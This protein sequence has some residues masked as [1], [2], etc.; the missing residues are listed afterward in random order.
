MCGRYVPPDEASLAR[1]WQVSRR[2]WPG[3]IKPVFN[4]APTMQV[5]IMLQAPDGAYELVGARWGLIPSWWSKAALPSLSFNARSEEALKKPMWRS[6]LHGQRCILP[7]LG[8][9]E[10]NEQE[11]TRNER[12]RKVNQPYF[13]HRQD[14]SVLAIAGLWSTWVGPDQSQILSCALLTR[15]AAPSISSIHHRMPVVLKP[16]HY[17]NWM[18]E[19]TL[20]SEVQAMIADS[21]LDFRGYAVSTKV[22]DVRN[23]GCEL[24]E[25][26]HTNDLFG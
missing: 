22:N 2:N 26:L 4:I 11:N 16:E 20:D 10:W 19:Q 17:A 3:W 8:W 25:P 23:D 5:P 1:F 7:A 15:E 14:G 13:I 9:Y 18:S 6:S 12:N 21:Q 24:L